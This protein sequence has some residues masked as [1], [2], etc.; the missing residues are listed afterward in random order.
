MLSLNYSSFFKDG[1]VTS[2]P[3]DPRNNSP[4][5][6]KFC[7]TTDFLE[8]IFRR[9]SIQLNS[10]S[11]SRNNN[12]SIKLYQPIMPVRTVGNYEHAQIRTRIKYIANNSYRDQ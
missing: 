7:H 6:S 3:P 5:A 11:S 2:Q 12:A 4:N 8:Y 1:P 10:I 9:R